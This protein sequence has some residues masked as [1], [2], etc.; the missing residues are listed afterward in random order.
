MRFGDLVDSIEGAEMLAGSEDLKFTSVEVDHRLVESGALF[1]CIPGSAFDGHD[2]AVDALER[3][4]AGLMTVHDVTLPVGNDSAEIRVP[5]ETIRTSV[6]MASARVVGSP[7]ERLTMI[8]VTGTNGKT[9]VAH[10]VADIL[11]SS[12]RSTTT[13]GTLTGAR[14]TPPAPELQRVLATA[15]S[16]ALRVGL[17]GA[18]SMEV[19][20]HALDQQRVEGI[21]FDVAI[22]TNLS[23]DHLDYHGTMEEYFQ[24]KAKLF[25][26]ATSRV[27][28]I[29][30]ETEEGERLIAGRPDG[31]VPVTM[32]I[33]E[34]LVLGPRGSTFRWRGEHVA[35][36]ILGRTGVID[37]LLAAEA[38]FAIGID[39]SQI[40]L[41]LTSAP[42]VPGRMELVDG[43]QGSPCVIVDYAH[44][45]DA[46]ESAIAEVRRLA[47]GGRVIVVFGCGGDRDQAKRP[48]MGQVADRL[49][50]HV[51]VTTDNPRYEDAD[52]IAHEVLSGAPE[53]EYEV[54]RGAAILSAVL[55]ANQG[56]VI[57][58]AGKGH[59]TT[60]LIG[61][62][63]SEFDDRVV[64]AA[65]LRI[66]SEQGS[67]AC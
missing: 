66:R 64:A 29:W 14:T 39:S 43:P 24:A 17:P 49:A 4:A 8:G 20:S 58:V 62:D 5:A 52:A 34:E 3:G 37:A 33:A 51:I 47:D 25:A 7:A 36:R 42:G 23:H 16:E 19:S 30:A 38:A 65:A 6:A 48:L 2:F 12:G 55:R 32:D 10:L 46:L 27:A 26:P 63:V 13:V 35:L 60:Q 11:S 22:F 9:T 1:C 56:D 21:V 45:P 44:T 50:D 54:D 57:L 53:A 41:A 59:E 67:G 15:E 18:V 40:A 28:V 31:G 61:D